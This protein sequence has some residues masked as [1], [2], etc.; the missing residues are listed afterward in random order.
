MGILVDRSERRERRR[1]VRRT[2]DHIVIASERRIDEEA[3]GVRNE[4]LVKK[5]GWCWRIM[6]FVLW[7]LTFLLFFLCVC[8]WYFVFSVNYQ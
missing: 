7:C 1:R 3:V 4:E 8:V 6:E 2:D 5:K